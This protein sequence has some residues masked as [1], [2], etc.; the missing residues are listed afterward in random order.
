MI[1][2]AFFREHSQDICTTTVVAAIR[3]AERETS[4]EIRVFISPKHVDDPVA[5]ARAEFLRRG[6]DQ[7]RA[8]NGVL[9]F[10]AFARA[11]VC[12]HR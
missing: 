11:Q 1:A 9:I 12:R 2:S 3:D 8:R 10:V 5:A 6:M 4:G 7:S